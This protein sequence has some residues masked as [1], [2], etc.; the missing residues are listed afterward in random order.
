ML[1]VVDVIRSRTTPWMTVALIA[2][3]VAAFLYSWS[4]TAAEAYVWVA[5]LAFVPA[6]PS[7]LT[8]TTSLFVHQNSVHLLLNAIVLWIFGDNVEDQLGHGRFLVLYMLSGHAGWLGVLWAT[9]WSADP[10]VALVGS[11]AAIAGVL[12]A[13]FVMFPRSRVLVLV[14]ARSIVDAVELPAV[15]VAAAWFSLQA[16]SLARLDRP[17]GIGLSLWPYVGGAVA[18]MLAVRVIRRPERQRVEWWGG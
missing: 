9:R 5:R 2:A 7:W 11:G 10:A 13:Y 4:L 12:G 14:P 1:P 18:G 8:A 16:L 17:Y 15:L 3:N 6:D